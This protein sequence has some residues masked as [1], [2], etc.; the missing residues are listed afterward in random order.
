[1]LSTGKRMRISRDKAC[2]KLNINLKGE[3][4]RFE[5]EHLHYETLYNLSVYRMKNPIE[6]GIFFFLNDHKLR[7]IHFNFKSRALF[8]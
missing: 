3:C 1:M 8:I 2:C 4:S 7:D 5:V 6:I